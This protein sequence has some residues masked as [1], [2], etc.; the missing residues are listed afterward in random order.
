MWPD[1]LQCT[2]QLPTA[3]DYLAPENSCA[4]VEEACCC[5]GGA[6]G[7]NSLYGG[8]QKRMQ[9]QGIKASV[10]IWERGAMGKTCWEVTSNHDFYLPPL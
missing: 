7:I 8:M 3:S 1:T 4:E 5:R 2:K 6:C 9:V 10:C